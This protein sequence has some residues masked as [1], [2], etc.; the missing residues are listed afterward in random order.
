MPKRDHLRET[1]GKSPIAQFAA[2]VIGAAF[3]LLGV[4]GFIP[5][6]TSDFDQLSWAGHHSGAQLL[7]VF[8]VSVLHNL[9]HLAFGF[10]GVVLA[11]SGGAAIAYLFWG[12]VTYAAL[13]LYG[14]AV[15][16]HGPLNFVPVDSAGN[17]LHLVLAVLMIASGLI[18]GRFAMQSDRPTA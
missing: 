10:A 9:I 8:A 14:L 15:D 5:G 2:M 6:I 12:G 7:G 4:G 13:W 16:H 3:L 1:A 11:R 18:L 17:W